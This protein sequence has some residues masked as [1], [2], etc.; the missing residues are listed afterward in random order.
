VQ[1]NNI[2]NFFFI[3]L[4]VAS[5]FAAEAHPGKANAAAPKPIVFKKS[6]RVFIQFSGF[7]VP[8][9]DVRRPMSEVRF[10]LWCAKLHQQGGPMSDVRRP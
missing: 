4:L 10:A 8:M 3:V 2:F 9:S 1:I 6:L 7:R 5:I